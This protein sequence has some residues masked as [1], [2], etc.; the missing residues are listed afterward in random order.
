MAKEDIVFQLLEEERKARQ[1]RIV[2]E[3]KITTDDCLVLGILRLNDEIGKLHGEIG[4]LNGEI[5]RL[6]SRIDETNARI[7]KMDTRINARIDEMDTRINA[8]ID[9]N[10]RW[11]IGLILGMWGSTLAILIPILLKVMA[12]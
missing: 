7:D 10:F 2:K 6:H 12:L 8:R 5:G 3:R 4:R 9:S 1:E 11:T